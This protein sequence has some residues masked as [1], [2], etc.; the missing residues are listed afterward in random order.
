MSYNL[1][2]S[3]FSACDAILVAKHIGISLTYI[4]YNLRYFNLFCTFVTL[5][6]R[7]CLVMFFYYSAVPGNVIE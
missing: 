3:V 5:S 6:F 7:L 2:V 4:I 1:F